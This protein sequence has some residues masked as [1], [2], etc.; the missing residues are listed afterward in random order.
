MNSTRRIFL[1]K[2]V[3]GGASVLALGTG[4]LHSAQVLAEWSK[5]AFEAET[6]DSALQALY[7]GETAEASDAITL[8]AP[9]IAENGAVVPISV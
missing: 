4:L 5:E 7:A 2:A 3:L 1:Q 9:D 6:L 8:K